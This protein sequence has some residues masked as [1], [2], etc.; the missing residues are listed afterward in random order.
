MAL[1]N[2]VDVHCHLNHELFKEDADAVLER[3]RKAGVKR[4]LVSGV[5]PTGNKEILKFIE[6]DKSLL[7]ASL[8]FYPID[9]LGMPPDGAG[10]PVH[11]GS[12]NLD[13]EF[14][15]LEKNKSKITAIGEIGMD[16]H[17]ASKEET[18]QKQSE[19]FRKIIRFAKKLQKPIIVHSR[20]AEEE[21]LEILAEEIK[22]Q[23]IP[24]VNH[25]FSGRKGAIR[26]AAALG[27]YFSIP[28]NIIKA[29]NF[30][31]LVKIVDLQQLLTETDA[32]WLSPF[33]E[34]KNEPAFVMET[35]KKIADIKEL[36]V[37]KA[38]EQIWG[39]YKKVFE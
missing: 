35:I 7:R 11:Y 37:E 39:N 30:Q 2:L 13:E 36:P 16:F 23:E 24:V 12:I 18:R 20:Q 33:K 17:W 5:N 21:C 27:H 3:A 10:L 8:G 9:L 14:V 28:P 31:S 19:N 25:C 15:F 22:Q 29:S 32:P 4:I 6:K 1:L 38:A 26:K 34:Q